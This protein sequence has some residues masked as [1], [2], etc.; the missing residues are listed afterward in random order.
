MDTEGRT[1]YPRG[2]RVLGGNYF[3]FNPESS[4]QEVVLNSK[5]VIVMLQT[6]LYVSSLVLLAAASTAFV[7]GLLEGFLEVNVIGETL[8]TPEIVI[9]TFFLVVLIGAQLVATHM[10]HIFGHGLIGF[11]L[12]LA[13]AFV[14]TAKDGFRKMITCMFL[15]SHALVHLSLATALCKVEEN[16]A[17]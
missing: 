15:A 8:I 6:I 13:L 9:F 12:I 16:G 17:L 10:E 2:A 7:L 1:Y 14:L 5:H 3:N 11:L 4:P